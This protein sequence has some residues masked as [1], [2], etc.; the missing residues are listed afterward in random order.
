MIDQAYAQAA[1]GCTADTTDGNAG[2]AAPELAFALPIDTNDPT[3]ALN[4]RNFNNT[5][6]LEMAFDNSNIA[7]VEGGGGAVVT[8]DPENVI[9]GLEFSIPLS[10]LGNPTGDIKLLAYINGTGHDFASNQFSGVGV[11]T[12]NFGN[13]PPDLSTEAEGD[14]FVTIGAPA[15]AAAAVPE[16]TSLMLLALA[17]SALVGG[18][19]R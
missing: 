2:C 5:V 17:A 12:G 18:R 11:L 10:A 6:G 9:T 1:G 4:H 16:P 19:R 15:A 7:G 13:L 8:G 3:N 14:Q